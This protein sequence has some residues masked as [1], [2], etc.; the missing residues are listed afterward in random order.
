MKTSTAHPRRDTDPHSLLRDFARIYG[1]ARLDGGGVKAASLGERIT[2]SKPS[3]SYLSFGRDR[4]LEVR[5]AES[6]ARWLDVWDREVNGGGQR[7]NEEDTRSAARKAQTKA[8]LGEVGMDPTA[9]AFIYGM[10]TDG[11]RKLRGRNGRDPETGQ[12]A[13][14]LRAERI[15]GAP[16][17]RAPLTAPAR[18][19]HERLES[20]HADGE[21]GQ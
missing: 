15:D 13:S 3:S 6:F 10:T 8:I 19:A 16:T 4:P 20:R 7:V 17:H 2:R 1:A 9:L 12:R 14:Q 5:M 18:V 11:V 21:V